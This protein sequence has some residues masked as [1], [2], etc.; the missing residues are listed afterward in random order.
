M[1]SNKKFGIGV[2]LVT[3]FLINMVFVASAG[4]AEEEKMSEF[5]E[6]LLDILY[7][8][9]KENSSSDEIICNYIKS[10]KL[11]SSDIKNNIGN[12]HRTYEL[13][14]GE[15]VTFADN[16]TIYLSGIKE[17]AITSAIEPKS[18][19]I[20]YTDNLTGYVHAYNGLGLKMYT[21]Y[22]KGYFEYDGSTVEDHHYNSWYVRYGSIN[23]WQ[24]SNWE[25]GGYSHSSGTYAQI[26]GRGN[27]HYGLEVNGVGIIVQDDYV[28]LYIEC[29]ED[30][31]Y[32]CG[33]D[34]T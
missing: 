4:A 13:V 24:V 29:D 32:N 22:T 31:D 8:Q 3:L 26:Y 7:A 16:G 19:S 10:N 5:E 12:E 34:I 15:K 33:Y 23:P 20:S 9:S 30:G 14:N 6:G 17:E 18:R 21:V 1:K 28:N 2:I 11:E 27:F 25:K